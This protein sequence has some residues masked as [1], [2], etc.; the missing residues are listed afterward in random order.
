[1]K[2]K[3][4]TET[5]I[6]LAV[7]LVLSY[8][9]SLVTASFAVPG[10]KLGLANVIT[11]LLL[12]HYGARRVFVFMT[13]RVC[14]AG[15]LFSGVAGIVYS[16]A[17]GSLCIIGM[18][19]LRKNP[20]FSIM[21]VSMAGAVFHN[22]GQLVIAAFVMENTHVFY[23]FPILSLSGVLAGLVIGYM[24]ALLILRIKQWWNR[25]EENWM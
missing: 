13:V 3:E 7:A 8:L 20:H 4:I 15:F 12:Y 17:G 22:I 18:E 19:L 25:N 23:Y 14:L 9:E 10:V 2:T 16:F 24:S 5:G 6:M 21:G 1:M 11:M